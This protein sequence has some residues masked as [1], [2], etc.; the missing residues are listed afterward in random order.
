MET[1]IKEYTHKEY[2]A[3][4]QQLLNSKGLYAAVE[5]KS[6]E[7]NDVASVLPY[8]AHRTIQEL[9]CDILCLIELDKGVEDE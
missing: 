1:I 4:M 8:V 5:E 7:I 3:D 9:L 2:M 6:D